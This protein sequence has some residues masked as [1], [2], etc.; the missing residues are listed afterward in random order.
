MPKRTCHH[1]GH[2]IEIPDSAVGENFPCP[3]CG[4]DIM[5]PPDNILHREKIKLSVSQPVVENFAAPDMA[6]IARRIIAN[7]QTVIVGKEP[8]VTLAVAGLFAEGYI[9]FEDVPGVAKTMLSRAIA[10]S[11]GCSFKRIQCTPDLSPDNVIGDFVPN[12]ATGKPDFR[13]GP[14]FS[15]MV[16]V[17]EINRASPRTQIV[18]LDSRLLQRGLDLFAGRHDK[19]WSLTDCISFVVMQ[20]EDLTEALTGDSHFEQA[21]F[22]ALLA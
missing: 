7:I 18:P 15:Q 14:L 5:M 1:C 11:I 12:P 19:N 2:A 20:D 10:Q 16:L 3:L 4:K 6:G 13:F 22:K 21:G 8:Q 17:D 9:L